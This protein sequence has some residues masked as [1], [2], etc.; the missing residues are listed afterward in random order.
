MHLVDTGDFIQVTESGRRPTS[1]Q[2]DVTR[3]TDAGFAMRVTAHR[4]DLSLGMQEW[5]DVEPHVMVWAWKSIKRVRVLEG[6]A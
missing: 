3:V 5:T 1:Y 2:G 6:A 4:A